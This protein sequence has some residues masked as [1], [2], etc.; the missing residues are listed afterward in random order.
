VATAALI[1]AIGS[2]VAPTDCRSR[3]WFGGGLLLAFA[4]VFAWRARQEVFSTPGA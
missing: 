4:G 3:R 1:L 2:F